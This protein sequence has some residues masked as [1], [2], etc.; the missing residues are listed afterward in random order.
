MT[1][2]IALGLCDMACRLLPETRRRWGEAMAAELHHAEDDRAALAFAGGCLVAALRIRVADVETRFGFGMWAIAIVT[3]LC[4]LFQLACGARGVA[5]LLGAPDGMRAALVAHGAGP[6]LTARYEAARPIVVGCFLAL[7]LAQLASAWLLSQRKMQ[8][9]A[10]AWVSTLA[11][12][13]LAVG[14]QLSIIW[15]VA[16]VPSEFHGLLVQA[17]AVPALL[18]WHAR[19]VRIHGRAQ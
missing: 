15:N 13:G 10:I 11:I 12:A 7:G 6:A 14:V 16:G 9:F 1:R 4:A 2:R 18:A 19:Q 3:A 8:A 5:V 17:I